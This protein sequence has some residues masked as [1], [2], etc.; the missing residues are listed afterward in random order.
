[1]LASRTAGSWCALRTCGTHTGVAWAQ[2]G[3]G[4]VRGRRCL[5][6]RI[7]AHCR[8]AATAAL[9]AWEFRTCVAPRQFGAG[10]AAG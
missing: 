1:M 2:H 5:G 10:T 9:R 8:C 4:R 7:G 3:C 6:R